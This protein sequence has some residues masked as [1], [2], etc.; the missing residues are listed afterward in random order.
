M[1]PNHVA[2][3][4]FPRVALPGVDPEQAAE[5]RRLLDDGKA[6]QEAA[7]RFGMKRVVSLIRTGKHIYT[8]T[9][10]AHV[11]ARRRARA[12]AARIS[13]RANR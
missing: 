9:V 3:Q 13:R 2:P 1:T 6:E 10:P 7:R 11:V 8:G 12:K 5:A 4:A